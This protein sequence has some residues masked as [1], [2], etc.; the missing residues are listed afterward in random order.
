MA[1]SD[2]RKLDYHNDDGVGYVI[3]E[4]PLA[5]GRGKVT[6]PLVK[7]FATWVEVHADL[8]AYNRGTPLPRT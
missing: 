7:G 3:E 4:M 1:H 2:K 6:G 8:E 5:N